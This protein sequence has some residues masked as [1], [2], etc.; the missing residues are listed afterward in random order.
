MTAA[1]IISL[2]KFPSCE[3]DLSE[4][5]TAPRAVFG[6]N[7]EAA[8]PPEDRLSAQRRHSMPREEGLLSTK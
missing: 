3:S 4:T 2:C 8:G 1:G 6:A 5:F 7:L